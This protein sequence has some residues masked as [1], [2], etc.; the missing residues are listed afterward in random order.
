MDPFRSTANC[1]AAED[2]EKFSHRMM[3]AAFAKKNRAKVM[4]MTT[5]GGKVVFVWPKRVQKLELRLWKPANEGKDTIKSL[6]QG[7]DG[8]FSL[9]VP[10]AETS[11]GGGFLRR[12]PPFG[13]HM[14]GG[15]LQGWRFFI[16]GNFD[17]YFDLGQLHS[18][19]AITSW[20]KPP[21]IETFLSWRFCKNPPPLEVFR[22]FPPRNTPV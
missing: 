9:E 19:S 8:R 20:R 6:K 14:D 4:M 13:S 5:G 17:F 12:F 15:S 18:N 16:I 1:I 22:R 10:S 3:Y 11:K 2:M 7:S 21:K